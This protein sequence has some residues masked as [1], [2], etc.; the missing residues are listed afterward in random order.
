MSSIACS[1]TPSASPLRLMDR[2]ARRMFLRRLASI[3][4]GEVTLHHGARNDT[5]THAGQP[6]DLHASVHVH[7]SRFFRRAIL[8]GSQSVA[9]AYVHGDWDCDDLTSLFRIFVRNRAST[10]RLDRGVARLVQSWHRFYH[11]LRANTPT[12]SRRNIA[13][14]YDLGNDFYRLWLDETMAYSSGIFPH[15]GTSMLQA[16]QEKFDRI[17]RNLELSASDQLLEIGTGWGGFALHAAENYGCQVTTTT[18]SKQQLQFA[19]QQVRK[20][21]LLDRITLLERDYRD[22]E[23]KFDK[24]VS[25][26]MIEAVGH[27]YLDQYFQKCGE[28]LQPDGSMMLQAIVMPERHYDR[29]LKTVD[30][31]QRSIFP[32]GCL[33]SLGA[34]LDSAGRTSDLKLIQVE[35]FGWHYAETLRRW[36]QAFLERVD[37]VRALGYSTQFIRLWN[38]YLCYCEAAFEERH[39]GLL[40]IQFD[41]PQ[42]RRAASAPEQRIQGVRTPLTVKLATQHADG[43]QALCSCGGER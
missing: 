25:I 11:W 36:R 22:L 42:R 3:R 17:C 10:E 15:A 26:E 38:Y 8:G 29:Y 14:H 28:L 37:E 30:F 19:A 35:D 13:A 16:S 18:I 5:T 31:I 2:L 20:H 1:S 39:I 7:R 6:A 32:G 21:G 34:I 40:Q 33:P 43:D 27:R 12:G 24:L 41:K 23:G 4:R 9:E